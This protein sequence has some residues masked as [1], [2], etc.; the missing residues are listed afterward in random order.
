MIE[1]MGFEV[2]EAADG[3]EAVEVF[4]KNL[5][6]ISFVLLDLTM[7]RMDGEECFHALLEL[8]SD[9]P[10]ILSSGYSEQEITGRFAG[11]GI[12]GFIQKP[13]GFETIRSKVREALGDREEPVDES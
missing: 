13:Y 4:R 8:K 2:L 9:V 6:A 11:L 12:R 10:V 7:P 1:L 3:R 5:D